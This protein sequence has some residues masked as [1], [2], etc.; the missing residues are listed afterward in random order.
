[1]RLDKRTGQAKERLVK[2]TLETATDA[3]LGKIIAELRKIPGLKAVLGG[4]KKA[5]RRLPAG[6]E[7]RKMLYE[8]GS[9]WGSVRMKMKK[10]EVEKDW[11]DNVEQNVAAA[12]TQDERDA[13]LK[14]HVSAG[15]LPS[16]VYGRKRVTA[17]WI[18]DQI[19]SDAYDIDH[20]EPI[21]YHWVHQGGNNA[22]DAERWGHATD[23]KNLRVRTE[24]YNSREGSKFEDEKPAR[25]SKFFWVGPKFRSVFAEGGIEHAEAIDGQKFENEP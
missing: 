23:T 7:I 9:G 1:M 17:A 11:L 13:A 25:F 19:M 14:P 12:R 21:A 16:F 22:D 2:V 3:A 6:Y 4:A 5:K 20:Y 15:R 24:E 8:R 10:D 18:K